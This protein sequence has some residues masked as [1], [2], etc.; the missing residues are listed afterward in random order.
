MQNKK[1]VS[2]EGTKTAFGRS[3]AEGES[4]TTYAQPQVLSHRSG[5]T[6]YFEDFCI[7]LLTVFIFMII[8]IYRKGVSRFR[9]NWEILYCR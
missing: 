7:F 6:F 8:F 1:C 3:R 9:R 2:R 5:S 4:D